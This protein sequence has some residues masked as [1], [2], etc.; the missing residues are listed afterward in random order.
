M[1]GISLPLK[2]GAYKIANRS[3]Y[4]FWE[5]TSKGFLPGYLPFELGNMNYW[6]VELN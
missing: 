4:Y 6:N 1:L 5:T 2:H 3:K